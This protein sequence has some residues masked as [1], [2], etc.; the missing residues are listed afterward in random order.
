MRWQ[1]SDDGLFYWFFPLVE[2]T[3]RHRFET[4]REELRPDGELNLWPCQQCGS[5][6]P[7]ALRLQHKAFHEKYPMEIVHDPTK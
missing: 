6:I 3:F 7:G 4:G 2:W 1:K 5:M